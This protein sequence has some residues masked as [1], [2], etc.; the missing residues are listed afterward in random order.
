MATLRY[1][2]PDSA[3]GN[4]TTNA[5]SGANAAYSSMSAAEA[6]LPASLVTAASAYEFVCCST[7]VGH[8]ADTSQC[9]LSGFV[10]SSTF[11]LKIYSDSGSRQAG[12]YNSSKYRMEVAAA[13]CVSVGVGNI[14]VTAIQGKTTNAVGTYHCFYTA[15]STVV[16]DSCICYGTEGTGAGF[17]IDSVAASVRN[18]IAYS[19]NNGINFVGN[20]GTAYNCTS[21]NNRANGILR[22][23]SGTPTVTNCYAG[24]NVTAD[25]SGT[26]TLTTSA[27]SDSTG[28]SGLRTIAVSTS[29]GAKFTN[30]TSGS[31]DF[32]LQSGSALIDVGTSLSGTFTND[33]DGVTRSGTWDIGADEYVSSSTTFSY[34]GSG[35]LQ[36]AGSAGLSKTKS[37]TPSGGLQFGGTAALSKTKAYAPSG[38]VQFGGAGTTSYVGASQNVYTY[39]G[40]GGLQFAGTAALAKAK[41]Y[42]GAGGLTLA[43]AATVSKTKA[44]IPSGGLTFAGSATL[45][46]TKVYAGSGL[47]QFGGSGTYRYVSALAGTSRRRLRTLMGAGI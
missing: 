45:S 25:Y 14:T 3:G 47:L 33:I 7:G 37:Y 17:Y 24:G 44:Y 42:A 21:V 31:E 1:I 36:F 4:G 2:D 23:T 11:D 5:L 20:S 27:S 41:A 30:V 10:T 46:K 29:T 16:F 22:S 15:V 35:G 13:R 6:A 34:S 38:G 32:H 26:M 43:G 12:K 40:S 28:T 19:A 9:V 39:S 18:C 8:S